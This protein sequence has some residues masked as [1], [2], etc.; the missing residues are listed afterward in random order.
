MA[1]ADWS[2]AIITIASCPI[3]I[4][5]LFLLFFYLCRDRMR[6]IAMSRDG[7]RNYFQWVH[8]N[9]MSYIYQ[10]CI[11]GML[12]KKN[13]GNVHPTYLEYKLRYRVGMS[14][15]TLKII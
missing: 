4:N 12:I 5:L 11:D 10:T 1:F 2:L 13:T 9:I 14:K 3:I 15:I 6:S 8:H 7:A